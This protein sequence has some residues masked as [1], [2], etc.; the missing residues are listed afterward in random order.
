MENFKKN[1]ISSNL[2]LAQNLY[3]DTHGDQ[4]A[5][6][7]MISEGTLQV[8]NRDIPRKY[9]RDDPYN[10]NFMNTFSN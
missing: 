4:I 7:K 1:S 10:S 6:L 2:Q 9:L 3:G 5:L 8:K